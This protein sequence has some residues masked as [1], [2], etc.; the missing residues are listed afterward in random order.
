MIYAEAEEANTIKA[1]F[2]LIRSLKPLHKASTLLIY[3]T[4]SSSQYFS[5]TVRYGRLII[6]NTRTPRVHSLRNLIYTGSMGPISMHHQIYGQKLS[7]LKLCKRALGI[8]SKTTN[9][10]VY[11]E[12]GRYPLFVDQSLKHLDYI[13][14]ETENKPQKEFF[15]AITKDK[16]DNPFG[17][18]LAKYMRTIP[19]VKIKKPSLA[20]SRKISRF[21]S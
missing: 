9:M 6:L 12:W 17:N 1:Y 20:P 19:P 3:L 7:H 2:K 11:A 14:N 5:M 16:W 13:H 4:I 10:A 18:Q 21:P 15:E 8:H